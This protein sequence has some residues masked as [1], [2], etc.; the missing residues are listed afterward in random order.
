[1]K[2]FQAKTEGKTD[3][4]RHRVESASLQRHLTYPGKHDGSELSLGQPH[5]T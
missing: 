1:M 4:Q 5:L 2:E 3:H